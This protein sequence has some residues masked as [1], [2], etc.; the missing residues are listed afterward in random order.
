LLAAFTK[1]REATISLFVPVCLSACN[2]SATS[3][4]ILLFIVWLTQQCD[5]KLSYVQLMKL[6]VSAP[7][8]HL[9]A[10]KIRIKQGTSE[11]PCMIPY[12]Y[13]PE[14]D[15]KG[16]KHVALLIVHNLTLHHIVV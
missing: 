16:L 2:N 8:G 12:F 13:K 7:W 4:R 1:L 11:V 10:Y 6:H 14:D 15:P 9:Q 5:V 3:G